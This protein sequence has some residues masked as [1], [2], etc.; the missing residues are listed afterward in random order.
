MNERSKDTYRPA[1]WVP[2]AHAQTM[3]AKFFRRPASLPTRDER[4]ETP[5]GDFLDLV[6][7][8]GRPGAP[9]LLLLHGLEGTR[10][11][12]YVTGLF[13]QARRRGWSATLLVFR[14]CGDELNRGARLYHSGETTDLDLVARRLIERSPESE[15]LPVGVSLGGNVLLKW[16][17]ERGAAVPGQIRGAAAVSVPFDLERGCR[18]LQRGFARVYD[19]H[20]VRTLRRKAAAKLRRHPGLFD[21]SRLAAARTIYDFD[22]AVTAP[23]HGFVDAHDYYTR[24]SSIRYLAEIA[25]PTLLLS[26]ID[27]PFLPAS[28]L[29][30]VRRV[31]APNPSLRLEF[32]A[33]GGHVGFVAGALPWRPVYYAEER[34]G[35]FFDSVL[36]GGLAKPGSAG[37]PSA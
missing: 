36:D 24:S 34:V 19:R 2:G 4:I 31:A 29:D 20:F 15:L 10:R 27:D 33:H 5:D 1:W 3:W 11:S 8:D 28:V 22:D 25:V 14:G 32:V 9:R 21:A 23:V 30:D 26:A 17:G 37:H 13:E 18:H 16:L 12:H 35:R 6:H 7:L